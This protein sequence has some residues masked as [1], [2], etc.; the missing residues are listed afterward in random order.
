[1][2]TK[3]DEDVRLSLQPFL[4]KGSSPYKERKEEFYT[5]ESSTQ[6]PSLRLIISV[7]SNVVLLLIL[8]FFLYAWR[9]DKKPYTDPSKLLPR[10]F[11]SIL[12]RFSP[13]SNAVK[14]PARDALQWGTRRFM[15]KIVDN[16]F[17]GEPRPE[18]EQAWHE[19]LQSKATLV[20]QQR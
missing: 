19:L 14:V 18:L 6:P 10:L 7:S 13:N 3:N 15:T 5:A 20:K 11:Q 17:A 1:M 9:V 8:A 4:E 2:A 16:P 12:R